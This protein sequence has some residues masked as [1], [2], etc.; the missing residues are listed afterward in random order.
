MQGHRR[1]CCCCCSELCVAVLQNPNHIQSTSRRG[2]PLRKGDTESWRVLV[3]TSI[4]R[5]Q[6]IRASNPGLTLTTN[7]SRLIL[8][9]PAGPL[10][11]SA[12][13]VGHP[14]PFLAGSVSLSAHSLS[15]PSTAVF[16][17][18]DASDHSNRL[19]RLPSSAIFPP[20]FFH[21]RSRS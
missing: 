5:S 11:G 8:A 17:P 1:C 4:H 6:N 10:V 3:P 13:L 16:P 18:A 12:I 19:L 20:D 2:A 14:P 7:S 21:D 15:P 9:L